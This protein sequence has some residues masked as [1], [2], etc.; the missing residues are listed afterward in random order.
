[1]LSDLAIARTAKLLPIECIAANAG[2]LRNELDLY[3]DVKAK[4]KLGI[5][6]RLAGAPRASTST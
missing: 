1:M 6:E 5:L 3:G 4:V 2:I